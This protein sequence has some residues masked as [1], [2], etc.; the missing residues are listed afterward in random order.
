MLSL[1]QRQHHS[2]LRYSNSKPSFH[3]FRILPTKNHPPQKKILKNRRIK[4]PPAQQSYAQRL[5]LKFGFFGPRALRKDPFEAFFDR[6]FMCSPVS[7]E[8]L[9][10]SSNFWQNK[11]FN[12]PMLTPQ[13]TK[14]W[15][16]PKNH[17]FPK[18]K[19]SSIPQGCRFGSESS[20]Q[21]L[22][23]HQY[24]IQGVWSWRDYML[25][26]RF[27]PLEYCTDPSRKKQ[28]IQQSSCP[29][30]SLATLKY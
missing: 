25:D 13:K 19:E 20:R 22:E 12:H 14:T 16:P 28:Y 6:L 2:K 4:S 17:G 26:F 23:T 8:K 24:W 29:L 18:K 5:Y 21:S 3:L 11:K 1:H 30:M 27:D 10:R 7:G 9:N 15:N